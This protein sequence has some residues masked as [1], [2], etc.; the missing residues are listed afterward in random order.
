[1]KD[2][3]QIKEWCH[4]FEDGRMPV[5]SY[6][7]SGRTSTSRNIETIEKMWWL[8]MEDCQIREIVSDVEN[9]FDS[10]QSILTH[11]LGMG[12]IINICS[13]PSDS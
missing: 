13:E 11:D 3:T 2:A 1:M 10:M 6:E 7:H 5:E 12:C 8:L 9:L 4:C